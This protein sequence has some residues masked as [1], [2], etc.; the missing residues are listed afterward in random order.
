MDT[1]RPNTAT[2]RSLKNSGQ[3]QPLLI[4]S[5]EYRNKA[6]SSAY[7]KNT[8]VKRETAAV[9]ALRQEKEELVKSFSFTPDTSVTKT[10]RAKSTSSGYG[11]A[12]ASPKKLLQGEKPTFK[13]DDTVTSKTAKQKAVAASSSYGQVIPTKKK[14][15]DTN[16]PTFTPKMDV[17]KKGDK[18]R[19]STQSRHKETPRPKTAP[20]NDGVSRPTRL[21]LYTLAADKTDAA[22]QED[23]GTEFD[24]SGLNFAAYAPEQNASPIGKMPPPIEHSSVGKKLL[25]SACPTGYGSSWV[26]TVE[27]LKK[28]ESSPA[29]LKAGISDSAYIV[30][31]DD[32]PVVTSSNKNDVVTNYGKDYGPKIAQILVVEPTPKTFFVGRNVEFP[33]IEDLAKVDNSKVNAKIQTTYGSD[34]KPPT[35]TPKP[36]TQEP[37]KAPPFVTSGAVGQPLIPSLEDVAVI[38]HDIDHVASSGY[39]LVST[40]AANYNPKSVHTSPVKKTGPPTKP[41]PQH[42]DEFDPD[43]QTTI[44]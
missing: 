27:S 11:K 6:R 21:M 5:P 3:F 18:L 41:K 33:A 10:A 1:P 30:N 8:A 14:L 29:P 25:K 38:K 26:P 32:L 19:Q 13:P 28:K 2:S 44:L 39:G 9:Q 22:Q 36:V 43:E 23:F 34:Y 40:H 17:S 31:A 12:I 4:S 24:L 35:T 15:V 37:G 7:G 20:A 16:A 42:T